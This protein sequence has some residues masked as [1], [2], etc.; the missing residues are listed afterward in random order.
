MRAGLTGNWGLRVELKQWPRQKR[1]V[2][3]FDGW[4]YV[5]EC[6]QVLELL[7][8]LECFIKWASARQFV[9]VFLN[10]SWPIPYLWKGC[11]L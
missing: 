8:L 11:C 4:L 2:S 1:W 3:L 9:F 7:V 6:I 10:V 5:Y